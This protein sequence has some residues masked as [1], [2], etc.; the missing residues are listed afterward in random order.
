MPAI[1]PAIIGLA[2][3]GIGTGLTISADDAAAS[4]ENNAVSQSLQNLNSLQSKATPVV[5]QQVKAA[6]TPSAQQDIQAGQEKALGDYYATQAG[7]IGN[8]LSTPQSG[9]SSTITSA[10]TGAK[11]GAY[12]KADAQLQG[13]TN[14]GQQWQLSDAAARNLLGNLSAQGQSVE[15]ALPA[16]LAYDRN[17]AAGQAGI[18][19]LLS[20]VGGV[21]STYGAQ[22]GAFTNLGSVPQYNWNGPNGLGGSYSF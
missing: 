4:A 1:I 10:E 18:G 12:T 20:S 13:Y 2:A 6:A 8:N 22:Q 19:S 3:T 21:A 15:S 17:S 5:S 16:T 14:L 7:G 9:S 11:E